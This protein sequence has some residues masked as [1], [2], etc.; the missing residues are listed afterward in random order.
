MIIWDYLG[1]PNPQS[2]KTFLHML[3]NPYNHI[4]IT[5]L[6]SQSLETQTQY[7]TIRLK[8]W[9]WVSPINYPNT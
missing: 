5:P 1:L 2:K 3:H 4:K 8:H 9:I 7:I 6:A